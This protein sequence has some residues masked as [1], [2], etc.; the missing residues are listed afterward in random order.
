MEFLLPPIIGAVIGWITNYAAIKLLFRPHKP[1][2]AFG[3]K[4]QGVIPKRRRAIAEGMARTIE[5][6]LFSSKDVA[7]LLDGIDWKGEIEKSVE[8]IVEHRFGSGRISKFPVVGVVADS[9]KYHLKYVITREILK[10]VDKKS[11]GLKSRIAESV[12]VEGVVTDRID[13]LDL[14]RFEELLLSFIARELKFL[15]VLGGIMGF[16]IGA[17]QS[18]LYYFTGVN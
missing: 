2:G 10:Q 6:E 7:S 5:K 18:A 17:M 9:L 14:N 15:E 8:E 16:L 12:D 11:H 4:F 13:R 3:L 1:I